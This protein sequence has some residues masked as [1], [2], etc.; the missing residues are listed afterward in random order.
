MEA[1]S[2]AASGMAVISLSIQLIQ[3]VD[4]IRTFIRN[5]KG[6]SAEL[7]RLAELLARLAAVLDDVRN[8]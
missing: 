1:L 5:V 7:E 3:S 8:L 6:A 2:G 4:K